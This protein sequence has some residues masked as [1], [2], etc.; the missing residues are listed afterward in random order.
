MCSGSGRIAN[1]V[2]D[3]VPKSFA[4]SF[5][6]TSYIDNIYLET[7]CKSTLPSPE[8]GTLSSPPSL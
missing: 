7:F 1:A 2:D 6:D 3:N 8:T 4:R 5:I